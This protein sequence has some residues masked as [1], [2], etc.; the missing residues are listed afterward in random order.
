MIP[1]R[2]RR[3]AAL[4]LLALGLPACGAAAPLFV[5]RG[6][7]AAYRATRVEPTLEGRLAAAGRY[8]DRY[9]EGVYA[10][11]VRA[12][13]GRAEPVFYEAKRGS[14]AGLEAYLRALPSGAFAGD[15]QGRLQQMRR[16]R[17][18]G[19]PAAR[20]A[21]EA[22]AR[23][24]AE[25]AERRRV[26]EELSTW[27]SRFLDAGLWSRPMSEAPAE[28]IIPFSLALPSP[29]CHTLEAGEEGA[30]GVGS[31]RCAKLLALPYT[32]RVEGESEAREAT[33]EVAAIEDPAG[34]PLAISIGGPD[35][36]LRL[37]ETRAVRALAADDA[38]ARVG[39][40]SQAA[41]LAAAAFRKRVSPDPACK[42]QPVAPVVLDLAC[43]GVRLVV[44]AALEP[45]GDD[46]IVVGPEP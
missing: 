1:R 19:D 5:G 28:V 3:A 40:I 31:M 26:R 37:E 43:A 39:G 8:L 45:G 16:A 17:A 44:R 9:P 34:R 4:G 23:I 20:V 6:E 27:V 7:Y 35:L 32:V 18:E 2:A 36:F 29:V 13:L 15:A 33:V 42:R 46:L 11:E 38:S 10:A 12:Y 30:P 25:Q 22:E 21:A 24:D 14:V 41:D